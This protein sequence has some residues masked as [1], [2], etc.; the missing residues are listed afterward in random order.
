M[1]NRLFP[2]ILFLLILTSVKAQQFQGGFFGGAVASQVNGDGLVGFNQPG[3][4]LGAFVALPY[5]ENGTFQME[6]LY[7]MKGARQLPEDSGSV[8]YASRLHYADLNLLYRYRYKS[9]GFEIG[10]TLSFLLLASESDLYGDITP[11]VEWQRLHLAAFAGINYFFSDTWYVSFRSGSSITPARKGPN[12]PTPNR[13]LLEFGSG[14][15]NI[16][17]AFGIHYRFN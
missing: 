1:H 14:Q 2:T 13:S 4:Q 3:L 8:L 16:W 11:D 5:K 6:L 15:Y 9:L 10:P 17:M 12:S 7:T